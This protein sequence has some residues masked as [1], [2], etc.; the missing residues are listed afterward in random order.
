M[1]TVNS[2]KYC[3][4]CES[5]RNRVW[6]KG[7]R[8]NEEDDQTDVFNINIPEKTKHGCSPKRKQSNGGSQDVRS[9]E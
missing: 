8:R 3:T 7:L 5:G 6:V 1:V 9:K 4:S 2:G